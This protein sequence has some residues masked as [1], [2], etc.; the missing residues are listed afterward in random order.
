VRQQIERLHPAGEQ[1][2]YDSQIGMTE[3]GKMSLELAVQEAQLF[4]HHYIDTEHMLLGLLC[5]EGIA[6]QV[7]R[8]S[9]VTID[10]ARQVIKQILHQDKQ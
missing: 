8:E 3:Q 6:S 10:K 4:K 7:L 2:I 5:E 9:G 1:P